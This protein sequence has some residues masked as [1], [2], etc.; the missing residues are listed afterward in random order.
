MSGETHFKIFTG[1]WGPGHR[2]NTRWTAEITT[3]DTAKKIAGGQPDLNSQKIP[4]DL[5]F[6]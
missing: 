6:G 3:L 2:L 5:K 4:G 1:T